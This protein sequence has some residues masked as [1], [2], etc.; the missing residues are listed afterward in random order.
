MPKVVK[1]RPM[2]AQISISIAHKE[3]L[4]MKPA[5]ALRLPSSMKAIEALVATVAAIG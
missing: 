2:S 1:G 3:G 4:R 5:N